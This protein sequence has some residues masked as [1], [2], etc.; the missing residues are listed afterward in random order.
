M[1][2]VMGAWIWL[3]EVTVCGT[4]SSRMRKFS[5]FSPGMNIPSLVSTTTSTVT[6]CERT[7]IEKLSSP[8]TFLGVGAGSS[9]LGGSSFFFGTAMGPIS[10]V[11]PPA[12]AGALGFCCA[13]VGVG[14]AWFCGL[15]AY[16]ASAPSHVHPARINTEKL[17]QQGFT[18]EIFDDKAFCIKNISDCPFLSFYLS[19]DARTQVFEWLFHGAAKAVF[20]NCRT[21]LV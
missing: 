19:I 16:P 2:A 20:V 15:C 11:G 14:L 5:F 1:T 9:F 7:V 3:K 21:R 17:R 4:L 12:S 13:G 6:S 8:S 18:L 10:P